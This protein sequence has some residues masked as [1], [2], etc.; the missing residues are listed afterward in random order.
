VWKASVA[1][2]ALGADVAMDALQAGRW[3]QA[4]E[5]EVRR[6]A[7]LSDLMDALDDAGAGGYVSGDGHGRR[8]AADNARGVGEYLGRL[9]I[10]EAKFLMRYAKW[11]GAGIVASVLCA[12]ASPAAEDLSNLAGVPPT[13]RN[14]VAPDLVWPE[15]VGQ[16]DVCLWKDDKVAAFTVTIDDNTKP[17]HAWWLEQGR[18]YGFRFT[19]FVVTDGL[20]EGKNPGWNGTWADFQALVDAGHDVQSHS[21]TH[22][23][24]TS[25]LSPAD[26]YAPSIRHIEENLRGVRCLTLAYPGGGLPNDR[27]VAAQFFAG[28]RG[29]RGLINPPSPD[30]LDTCSIGSPAAT[31]TQPGEKGDWASLRGVAEKHPAMP[32]SYRG[33]YCMHFHGVAWNDKL[34]S[35]VAP[36]AIE[37]FD[38]VKAREDKFWMALFREVVLYGQERDTARL[39]VTQVAASEIRFTLSDRMRDDWYDYPLTVKVRVPDDWAGVAA[40]QAEREVSARLIE[41]GGRRFALVEAVPDRGETRLWRRP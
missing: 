38:Y 10:M 24:K 34:K 41:H 12:Q 20:V 36:K 21:V 32:K 8:D 4:A 33:W 1:V 37:V 2:F 27:E 15:E 7:I 16:A 19:W 35:E 30:Y 3:R 26:D 25:A 5:V 23:S 9:D 29:T 6:R 17:D 18:T 11:M 28:A 14:P 39:A 40:T 13:E 31:L 22:R